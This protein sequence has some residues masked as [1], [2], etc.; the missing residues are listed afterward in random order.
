MRYRTILGIS[1][2]SLTTFAQ[3]AESLCLQKEQDIQHEIELARQHDN[4][5]RVTGLER[6]LTEAR[7]GCTDDKLKTRHQEKIKEQQQKVE[8]RQKELSQEKADGNDKEKIAKR[9]RKL[10]EAQRELKEVQAAPY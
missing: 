4:Q 8:E 3:A 7:A 5:R 1:L 2:L 9:E 10:A 6:A